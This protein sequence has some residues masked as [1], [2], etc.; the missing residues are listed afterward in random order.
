MGKITVKEH[1]DS[2]LREYSIYTI[3]E[4]ALPSIIDGLKPSQRKS[5]HTAYRVAKDKQMKTAAVAGAVMATGAY[6][7]GMEPL[8]EAITSMAS[9]YMNNV[10]LLLGIGA[11][12]S[13]LVPHAAAAR[14]TEVRL[15]KQIDLYF[16]DNDILTEHRDPE[17]PEPNTYLPIIPW[18]LVNGVSGIAT[19]F[20]TTILPRDPKTLA[21]ACITYLKT[22]NAPTDIVP[23]FPDF[24]GDIEKTETGWLVK[25]KIDRKSQTKLTVTEVPIG[26]SR[27]KYIELLDKLE[28]SAVIISYEDECSKNGFR[29]SVVIPRASKGLSDESLLVKLKLVKRVSE[30]ISVVD[31]DNEL[32]LLDNVGQII[33]YF[34]DYRLGKYADR[35]AH[36]IDRDKAKRSLLQERVRFCRLIISGAIILRGTTRAALLKQLTGLNF[37]KQHREK[38]VDLPITALTKDAII[39]IE[40][41]I[42]SL[43]KDIKRWQSINTT[44][45]YIKELGEL[46]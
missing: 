3:L 45:Q 43:D 24:F 40:K 42:D 32:M 11:F 29:F 12:G 41:E 10:P 28:E 13:R 34:V 17:M 23:K 22:N 7:H 8:A 27:E 15:S 21:E 36:Y 31:V 18:V 46:L 20:A 16:R 14:Y 6:H 19:G 38:F 39:R 30:N 44:K 25:G 2:E 9:P 26:Y 33:K 1:V 4:R 37:I 5:L 35:Y